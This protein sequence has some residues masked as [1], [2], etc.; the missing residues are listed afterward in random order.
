MYLC[1]NTRPNA[2]AQCCM[3]LYI[4]CIVPDSRNESGFFPLA[5]N[6]PIYVVDGRHRA[7]RGNRVISQDESTSVSA[8]EPGS[9]RSTNTA[10]RRGIVI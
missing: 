8:D 3:Y 4:L 1:M 5:R 2:F 9:S 10:Y 6:G 7:F